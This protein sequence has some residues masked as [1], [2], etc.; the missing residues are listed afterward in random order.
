MTDR[1]DH[2]LAA[3]LAV[4]RDAEAGAVAPSYVETAL[5]KAWDARHARSGFARSGRARG[6]RRV[7]AAAAAAVLTVGLTTLGGVLRKE[8]AKPVVDEGPSATIILVGEPVSEGEPVRLVRM[9]VPA[10]VLHTLGVRSTVTP[11]DVSVD[12]VIGEDG[13]AR[14]I[15]L[16]D[17]QLSKYQ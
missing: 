7:L 16:D 8:T 12:V 15:R 11:A 13:V 1:G 6:I 10:A 14:A 17:T 9:R 4:L 3:L 5:M 2:D